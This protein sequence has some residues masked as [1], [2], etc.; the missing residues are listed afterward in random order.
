[1]EFEVTK[2]VYYLAI[3]LL[4]TKALGMLTR[5]LGLPQVVGMVIAGLLIGPAIF[6]QLP[7][8]FNGLINPTEVEMDVL[9]TFSQIGVI[10]ILF[11]S[12]LETDLRDLK[13]SGFASSMIA[14]SGVVVPIIFGTIGAALFM[15]GI[16]E[17]FNDT[18][19]LLNALFVGCILTATSV[20]ITVETLRE[21]GKLNSKLGTTILSA[22]IIDDVIGIIVLSLIT[23]L[24]GSS[25][26]IFTLLKAAG[27]FAFSIGLGV[28]LRIIFK[29]ISEKYPHKRR[30][31]IFALSMCFLYAY[32][33]EEFFGIAAI[34]GAYMAGVM[35]SGLS[36]TKFVDKKILVNGYMIFSPIFFAYIGISAD[37][38]N[39]RLSD[40]W[41]AIVFVLIGIIAKIIGCGS[42]AK[43][44]KFSGKESLAVG[45]GMIARGEVALAVYST[46]SWLIYFGEDG[47]LLGIDP[48]FATIMLIIS[49]SILCPILL[50]LFL[51]KDSGEEK[52]PHNT[53]KAEDYI[54]VDISVGEKQQ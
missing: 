37:F 36:D 48:L 24:N 49:T 8:G 15:G 52:E 51:K 23:S 54:S 16:P 44:V 28:V 4:A 7:I 29:W 19:K 3:I 43:L 11:S 47:T 33:A 40:V 30:T 41:F 31:G 42:V 14:L 1:M 50:K 46:A 34:T 5:K 2:I 13:T 38:S 45:C 17:V 27:F 26:P 53:V 12:G 35:L 32:C 6:S 25:N 9:Q 10:L 22:A 20:G 21:I 18:N 39:F